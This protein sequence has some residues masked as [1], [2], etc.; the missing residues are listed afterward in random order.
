MKAKADDLLEQAVDEGDVP[1]VVACA[2][3]RSG[4]TYEGSFGKRVLGQPADMTPD[5]VVWIA[6]MTKAITSVAAMQQVERG[7]LSLD[8]PAKSVVP[9]LGEVG[10]LEGFDAGG[11]PKSA[12]RAG[13]SP[14]STCLRIPAAFPMKY[15]AK[16]SPGT[17]R[18]WTCRSRTAARTKRSPRRC[19]STR[20]TDGSTASTSTGPE[21]W[22]RP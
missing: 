18:S 21:R 7:K 1:G 19:S 11:M 8:D 12:S 3:T 17:R 6:S 20:A 15:G 2:T 13:T 10:V 4:A 16:T 14:S 5:T 22:S 9:Y